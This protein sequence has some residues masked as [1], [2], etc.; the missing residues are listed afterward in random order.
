L[1]WFFKIFEFLTFFVH[2]RRKKYIFGR[3]KT[4]FLRTCAEGVVMNWEE[5]FNTL[6]DWKQLPAY[7]LETRVDSLIGYFLPEIL[8][9]KFGVDIT[10]NDIFPEF[11][12]KKE[13]NDQSTKID[14]LTIQGETS[15]IIEI[16]TDSN[17][18]D[19]DQFGV[20]MN[21]QSQKD[22]ALKKLIDGLTTIWNNFHKSAARK[23][24]IKLIDRCTKYNLIEG[25]GEEIPKSEYWKEEGFFNR[26]KNISKECNVKI[27]YILPHQP[28][29][30]EKVFEPIMENEKNVTVIDFEEIAKTL[31]AI[32][33]GDDFIDQFAQTLEKWKGE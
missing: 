29:K 10:L 19:E 16:K 12:I 23:K 3:S 7:K 14:F 17:S 15:Y 13:T 4:I 31:K 22:K 32:R 2:I 11:P 25:D 30:D 5:Y 1:G 8:K 33:K 20:Y 9:E 27:I 18:F 6:V 26:Y 28:Q 24:Y 21:I